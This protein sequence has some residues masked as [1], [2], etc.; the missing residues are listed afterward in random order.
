MKLGRVVG[1]VTLSRTVPSLEG[2]RWLVVTPLGR[3]QLAIHQ[4]HPA[5]IGPEASPIVYDDMGAWTGDIVG[6]IEGGEASAP[7]EK[8]TPVDAY[9]A[10]IFDSIDY[11]PPT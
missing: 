3:E 4:T 9:N 11:R 2:A 5:M 1:R 10:A 7:F 8:P 6:F